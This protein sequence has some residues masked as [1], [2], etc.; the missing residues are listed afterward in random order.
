[1]LKNT[2]WTEKNMTNDMLKYRDSR[3]WNDCALLY[4]PPSESFPAQLLDIEGKT[5]EKWLK[6]YKSKIKQDPQFNVWIDTINDVM[7]GLD[8]NWMNCNTKAS[9]FISPPDEFILSEKSPCNSRKAWDI[10]YVMKYYGQHFGYDMV[11]NK[12]IIYS[13]HERIAKYR[14]SKILV[15]A[16]GPSAK[17]VN[18]HASEYDYVFSCN[19][20]FLNPKLSNIK[21]DFAIV[22]GEVDMRNSNREFHNYM[23]KYDTL[24]CFEDRFSSFASTHF[25]AMNKK[26]PDRCVF[27]HS[28]YRGKPGAGLRLLLYACMFGA[29]EIHFVGIDGMGPNTKQGDLHGH[30]F[31]QN[32]K[33]SHSSLDYGLYRRH[34]VMF[35]DYIINYLELN[36]KI[37]F[38]NLGEGHERNQSTSI[39]RYFFPLEH[40]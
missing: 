23:S 14:N 36:K 20:F 6:K 17:Q 15:I 4:C 13:N 27:A 28:R 39:S 32:K 25:S 18:W 29:S 31:Q 24:L 2:Y 10:R 7:F 37:K 16:G 38:Q 21:V 22:G 26:Y 3:V 33:Y 34:Y 11:C 8:L 40:K 9:S 35:W 5:A 1:M 30:A 12:E 19:H